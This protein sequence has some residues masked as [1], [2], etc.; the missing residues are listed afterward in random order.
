MSSLRPAPRPRSFAALA[1]GLLAA[2]LAVPAS[3]A[4][5]TTVV[6]ADRML[7]VVSGEMVSP[8]TVVVREGRIAAVN[9]DRPP[10]DAETVDLGDVTL[11]PGLMDTHVHLTY[12]LDEGFFT[13]QVTSTA[14]DRAIRGVVNAEKVLMAG[15]TTVRNVG[16][17]HFAD[18]AL[19]EASAE[20]RVPAP[21]IV[22][23]AHALSITGGHCDVTGF[24]PGVRELGPEQGIADGVDE[25][26]EA[27]RYQVKHGAGAIKVCATAGV[28]SFEESVGAQ[29]YSDAE[30]RAI[31][32]ET[33]RHGL[34]VAAHAHGTGGIKAAVRAGVASVEHGSVLDEE[35]IRL[36]KER[37][38]YLVPTTHLADAI[39]LDAL[40]PPVREKAERILPRAKESVR[41]AIDAGVKIAFGTD[42]PVFPHGQNGREFGALVERGMTPLEAIRSAT[43]RAADLLGAED[44]GRIEEGMLADL[45]AVE[46]DPLEDI[47][48]MEEVRFVMKDGR[49]YR[50]P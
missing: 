1:A 39:D 42:T 31:V 9:P 15:F 44:R 4:A 29:Q 16:A 32:E 22:P 28:L 10:E 17:R 49:V 20:N 11:L 33:E 50:R 43:L 30:L 27:V 24:A 48:A 41:R 5:Q 36:M 35:A 45:V 23:A 38:A 21:R 26:V 47:H 46:G 37:G 8:A 14:A 18:V 13:R 6:R 3:L 12:D 2:L 40:P 7:D 25:V 19:A 34:K